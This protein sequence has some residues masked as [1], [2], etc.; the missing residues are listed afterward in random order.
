MSDLV[1]DDEGRR[2]ACDVPQHKA[3]RPGDVYRSGAIELRV[4]ARLE[5]GKCILTYSKWSA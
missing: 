4:H 3:G 2:C 1:G 5:E